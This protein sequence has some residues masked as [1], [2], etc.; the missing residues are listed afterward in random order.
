MTT[1]KFTELWP[2][3]NQEHHNAGRQQPEK[4]AYAA[5]FNWWR[6]QLRAARSNLPVSA[7]R[8]RN[9]KYRKHVL[10]NDLF[11]LDALVS[12]QRRIL[13]ELEELEKEI[14]E[15]YANKRLVDSV[16]STSQSAKT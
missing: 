10:L 13:L 5:A 16:V 12:K 3:A 9:H 11:E 7:S 6:L 15:W 4:T 1:R 8:A 14:A 2:K